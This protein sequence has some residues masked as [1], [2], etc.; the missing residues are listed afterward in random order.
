MNV[1]KF[2]QSRQN[3]WKQLTELLERSQRAI[4]R[5]SPDEVKTLGKLY[6]AATSDLAVAQR[7]YPRHRMTAYL[8]QLVARGH[9]CGLS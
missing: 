7:E 3:E 4:E 9:G 1:E 8:N 5:L 2:H 6:R